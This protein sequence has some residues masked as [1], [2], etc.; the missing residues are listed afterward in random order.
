VK[1]FAQVAAAV[2]AVP[3]LLGVVA[4]VVL[5]GRLVSWD[6]FWSE[7]AL[8]MSEA[9]ALN[10][11]A[12]IQRL[13]WSGDNPNAPARVRPSILKSTEISVTPLEASVGTRT[14]TTLQFLLSRGARMDAHERDV[15][16]CLATE[17]EAR[18]IIEYLDKDGRNQKPDCEHVATPW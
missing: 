3:A 5:A 13:I 17:D 16:F 6:P 14:P 1:P 9:A 18:E 7:P 15:I 11:R 8:T 2:A 12:T 4:L 10:D